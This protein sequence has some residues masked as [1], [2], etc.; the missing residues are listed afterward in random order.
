MFV[1]SPSSPILPYKIRR[2]KW[3]PRSCLVVHGNEAEHRSEYKV[4]ADNEKHIPRLKKTKQYST[5]S[6]DNWVCQPSSYVSDTP[7]KSDEP[8]WRL[9]RPKSIITVGQWVLYN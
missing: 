8:F 4:R 5:R 3:E 6:I 7:I 2:Q 1:F 9:Q